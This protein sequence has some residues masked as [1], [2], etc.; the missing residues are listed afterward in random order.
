M[1]HMMIYLQHFDILLASLPLFL[2]ISFLDFGTFLPTTS[3]NLQSLF[4][5]MLVG[6]SV[7]LWKK[8]V[9]VA[10]IP[11]PLTRPVCSRVSKAKVKASLLRSTIKVPSLI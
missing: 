7:G 8:L 1:R 11:I 9:C 3:V 6:S 5:D 10:F 2:G 4:V